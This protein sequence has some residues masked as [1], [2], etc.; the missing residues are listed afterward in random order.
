MFRDIVNETALTTQTA[1]EYFAGRI[2][3][4]KVR[5][6]DTFVA[7]LRALLY[8]RI[9]ADEYLSFRYQRT[10]KD[11]TYYS[12]VDSRDA[13][14]N[15]TGYYDLDEVPESCIIYHRCDHT[16]PLANEA[17]IDYI[18]QTFLKFSSGWERVSRVTDFF[19]KK[20]KVLCFINPEKKSVFLFT[21]S[22]NMRMY[23]Y[24]QCGIFAMLPW[25]FARENGATEDELSVIKSLRESE[26]ASY[27]DALKN[28]ASKLDFRGM[29]IRNALHGFES[30]TF[31]QALDNT[32]SQIDSIRNQ[33]SRLYA[34]ARE[35]LAEKE[36]LEIKSLGL[37]AKIKDSSQNSEY[38]EYFLAN[39]NLTLVESDGTTVGL[40]ARGYI[41]F[42]DE[43]AAKV[44]ID[45]E[46]GVMYRDGTS[47]STRDM[48]K[49]LYAVFI[50]HR[51]RMR[52]CSY[53]RLSRD[54]VRVQSNYSY[55]A[56]FD[57]CTPNPH[58]DR[59][60]CLGN[61]E[62]AINILLHEADYIGATE[63][64]MASCQS[65][66][67]SDLYVM[68]EFAERLHELNPSKNVRC[69]ELPDGSVVNPKQAIEWL[70][71]EEKKQE[72]E[73]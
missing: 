9:P 16:D 21:G 46:T 4:D 54:G 8:S 60:V 17:A 28:I 29:K 20:T 15:T 61:Y 14:L 25:Y 70:Y 40:I 1:N 44:M 47:Y 65:L 26:P 7:T 31:Q 69:F 52:V 64:C 11:K 51:I 13:L 27:L 56:E 37:M 34:S 73:A 59:Y 66:N 23:H 68:R 57:D 5:N 58:I 48:K 39:K 32:A 63:Q 71:N 30:A 53:Y 72:Q 35:K 36:E 12:N 67:F 22:V 19:I 41:T 43:E 6:D 18:D 24:I 3:G 62:E 38:M 45:N 42:F 33:I 10:S 49:L 55:G 2:W 50:E